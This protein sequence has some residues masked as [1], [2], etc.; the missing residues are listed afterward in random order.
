MHCCTTG[1]LKELLAVPPI[2]RHLPKLLQ[3]RLRAR[4]DCALV[5]LEA[6][7]ELSNL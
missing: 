1:Q 3:G 6:S 4:R 2:D 5:T 7:R